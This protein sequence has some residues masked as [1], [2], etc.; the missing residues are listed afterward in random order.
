MPSEIVSDLPSA[1]ATALVQG[2][3]LG[4]PKDRDVDDAHDIPVTYVLFPDEG[5]GFARPVNRLAF[6]ALA[7]Q[8]LA[9]HLGG[10]AEPL[11]DVIDRSTAQVS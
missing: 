4:V 6:M 11:G 7:E 5:H 1:P 9:E 8:F 10:R 2:S 3:A